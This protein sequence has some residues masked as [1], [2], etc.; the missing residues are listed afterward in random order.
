MTAHDI[1]QLIAM[2]ALVANNPVEYTQLFHELPEDTAIHIAQHTGHVARIVKKD[3]TTYI[4]TQD[5]RTD[6]INLTILD[7][8]VTGVTIG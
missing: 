3:G 8:I 6:R 5:Y 1:D 7:G 2:A 4:I